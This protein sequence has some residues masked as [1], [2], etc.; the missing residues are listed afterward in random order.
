M[1]F[2]NELRYTLRVMAKNA[3]LTFLC[4]TVIAVGLGLVLPM[5]AFIDNLAFKS[6]PYPD[7]NR[8]VGLNKILT[9][10]R[11]PSDLPEF[12]YFHYRYFKDNAKS[13]DA[14]YAWQ[15]SSLA[16]S[17]GEYVEVYQSA[18]LE[19]ELLQLPAVQPLMGRL[20]T[21]EDAEPGAAPVA[22]I[23]A[24][25]WQF[26]YL[27]RPDIIGHRARINGASVTIVGVMPE[28]FTFPLAQQLWMPLG[29][30]AAANAG[31]GEENLVIVGKLAAGINITQASKE[32]SLL[33]ANILNANPE[34]YPAI[35][36]A[37]V[38]PYILMMNA[39]TDTWFYVSLLGS[40]MLLVAINISNLFVARGEERIDELAIRS[41]LGATPL[42]LAQTMLLES[43]LVCLCGL[44]LG[45]FIA[46]FGIAY[47][48][49]FIDSATDGEAARW[50]WWDM[51]LNG[52]MITLS[53][54]TMFAI[55]LGSGGLP[56]WRISRTDLHAAMA[57]GGKGAADR[58]NS[59]VVKLL[60]NLQLVL[61]CV[62]LS[63]GIIQIISFTSSQINELPDPD[64]LYA[65]VV[66]F[67]DTPLVSREDK[68]GYLDDLQR[69]LANESA[70]SEVA[71]TSAVPFFGE[72]RRVS[73]AIEDQELRVNDV[74]P[75]V[76][77][78]FVSDNYLDA[79]NTKISAGR[80]FNA[81]DTADSLAV[82]VIDKRIA[83]LYWPDESALGKRIQ[84][85]PGSDAS[86]LTIIGISEPKYFERR[87]YTGQTGTPPVYQPIRQT[88]LR[89]IN[90][91]VKFTTPPND[92]Q[93]LIGKAATS[94]SRDV[95]VNGLASFNRI[96]EQADEGDNFNFNLFIGF[97]LIALYLCGA[98]TYGLAARAASRR[99][100]E[101]GIRM[102]LGASKGVSMM[103][104][105]K[106]GFRMVVAG[107]GI[108]S[109]AAVLLSYWSLST[110]AIPVVIAPVLLPTIAGVCVI[111][112]T[113][114]MLA[115]Y[116]PA[117]RIIAME[118]GDAL[119][120]E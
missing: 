105:I 108:G 70:V 100:I 75:Q 31:E 91:V 35:V 23:S 30:P 46:Y 4:V 9:L 74:Y 5:Y 92:A 116:F 43:F 47:I 18:V 79:I 54:L 40:I 104:F 45:L 50:F 38:V 65:A 28:G 48:G 20:F 57:G 76:R 22:I 3:R 106:D 49:S 84:L 94:T 89:Q 29:L 36:S 55:W 109:V 118:P 96:G 101:T 8:Y 21:A 110:N 72:A 120:H 88:D 37:D 61:G 114:V 1:N 17:D 115:N 41:A 62:L 83:D 53:V 11:R 44:S 26:Y 66:N 58:G 10:G 52:R 2:L 7:G 63:F 87:L 82:A 33:E 39:I 99:R 119:R 16:V 117:K 102:A 81:S 113:L 95:P 13:F 86:W 12:D 71:F 6:P 19:P 98:A 34:L 85:N 93:A 15:N 32:V 73:F 25:I 103:V 24:E 90:L 78:L 97:I 111:M 107:L 56:A 80:G 112:G 69:N 77:T 68:L 14:L 64:R 59:R 27:G 51:S 42:R 67:A 60:V